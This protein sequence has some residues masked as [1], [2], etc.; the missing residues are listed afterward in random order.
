M[1]YAAYATAQTAVETPRDLEIRAI[2]HITRKLVDANAPEVEPLDRIR[3]LNGNVRLWSMLMED[4]ADPGNALPE[5]VKGNYISLGIFARR[6]SLEALSTSADL[7][8]LIRI[9]VDVLEAL[10][11]QRQAS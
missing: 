1:S 5:T 10:D 8:P 11:Q 3:A 4:L 6:A 7:A 2:A 9:N